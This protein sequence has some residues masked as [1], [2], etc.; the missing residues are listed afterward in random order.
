VAAPH[1]RLAGLGAPI[2]AFGRSRLG[3]GWDCCDGRPVHFVFLILIPEGK[4]DMQVQ[5]LSS[6][7]RVMMTGDIPNRIR[8]AE[9]ANEVL[10][11]LNSA[12]GL[13]HFARAAQPA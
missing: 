5:I 6:V 3:I 12:L 9:D 10:E 11:L 2:V 1:A 8:A 4:T 7:A 13:Q